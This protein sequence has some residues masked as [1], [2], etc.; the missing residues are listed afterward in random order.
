[1]IIS[2]NKYERHLIIHAQREIV[3][4]QMD[5]NSVDL[6]LEDPP[7]GVREEEWDD[8]EHFVSKVGEWLN[9]ALRISKHAVIWFCASRMMPH[10]FN[11]IRGE[12]TLLRR[13][14]IWE[15]PEGSQYA[16]ASNNNIWFSMEPILVFSKD[17]DVTKKYGQNMP[18]AYDIFKYRTTPH[19]LYKH[20]TSKP[21]PLI[22][23][24]MGHYSG[25]DETIFDGFAG[26]FSM[27]VAGADM[28]RRTMSVEQSDEHFFNGKQRLER[29]L[30]E[31]KLFVGEDE[32]KEYEMTMEMF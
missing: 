18:Y 26:S 16:G 29:H 25:S 7:F 8:E 23:K 9:S 19:K 11:H 6:V 5:D 31:P 14:H 1:M 21:V 30:S 27:A 32:A 4:A 28:G 13:V 2:S 12:E 17:W 20:P 10:I 22:R 15:K 3:T 24:L